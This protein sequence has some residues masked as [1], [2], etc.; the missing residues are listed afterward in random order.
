M[1]PMGFLPTCKE[2]HRLT[3]EKFDRRLSYGERARMQVHLMYCIACRNFEGQMHLIRRAM[4]RMAEPDP[5]AAEQD[6]Q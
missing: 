1:N 4:R 3:S 2:V 6:A 5:Q